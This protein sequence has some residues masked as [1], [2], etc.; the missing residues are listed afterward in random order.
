MNNPVVV[1]PTIDKK[2]ILCHCFIMTTV[3]NSVATLTPLQDA[4]RVS[5]QQFADGLGIPFTAQWM[6]DVLDRAKRNVEHGTLTGSVL[7]LPPSC[8][9]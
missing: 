4:L 9:T 8:I 1:V 7:A 6:Q 2:I 3:Q 5:D